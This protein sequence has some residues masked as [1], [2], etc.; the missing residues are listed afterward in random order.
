MKKLP[1]KIARINAELFNYTTLWYRNASGASSCIVSIRQDSTLIY[2]LSSG[3][4]E[5]GVHPVPNLEESN[6]EGVAYRVPHEVEV[7]PKK[8]A[9][10]E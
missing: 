8:K 9:G 6:R 10:V 1:R 7:L 4:A 5:I 3:V 2:T